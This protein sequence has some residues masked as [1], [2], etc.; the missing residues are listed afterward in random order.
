MVRK[1]CSTTPVFFFAKL[2]LLAN[3]LAAGGADGT[4]VY[5][6]RRWSGTRGESEY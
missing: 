1:P 2:Y 3:L 4:P 6:P 5:H